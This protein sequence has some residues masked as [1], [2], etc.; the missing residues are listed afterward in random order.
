MIIPMLTT[1][2]DSAGLIGKS[3]I[4]CQ[5]ALVR[6]LVKAVTYNDV[7]SD[8]RELIGQPTERKLFEWY[9]NVMWHDFL[10]AQLWRG[11][12]GYAHTGN[13]EIAYAHGISPSDLAFI[14]A[15]LSVGD[16][17]DI[18]ASELNWKMPPITKDDIDYILGKVKKDINFFVFKS[19]WIETIDPT[20]T[21]EDRKSDF[22]GQAMHLI[23]HYESSREIEHIVNSVRTGLKNFFRDLCD[24]WTAQKRTS[25]GH[26]R[27]YT[28]ERDSNGEEIWETFNT[29]MQEPLS[30]V[31]PDGYENENPGI[32]AASMGRSNIEEQLGVEEFV[33]WVHTRNPHLG[34]Y[35]DFAVLNRTSEDLTVWLER[36]LPPSEP[37]ADQ[38]KATDRYL[39]MLRRYCNVN[40]RDIEQAEALCRKFFQRL[41][42]DPLPPVPEPPRPA[43][44]LIPANPEIYRRPRASR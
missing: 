12:H 25:G 19:R 29:K 35:L 16:I 38:T 14:K 10:A 27:R 31:A 3:R 18:R 4:A 6:V 26:G 24:T 9:R 7:K 36:N 41:P 39:R 21:P 30:L 20:C 11:F 2:L 13:T 34:E 8:I 1:A 42:G 23:Y 32:S 44:R 37:V 33:S 15:N 28:G 5:K 40:Q 17:R 43:A 22:Q